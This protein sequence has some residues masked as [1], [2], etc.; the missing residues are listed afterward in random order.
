MD[1]GSDYNTITENNLSGGVIV[2]LSNYEAVDH[3]Y[4]ND[5]STKYPNATEID[6]SGAGNQPYV[7]YTAQ[8]GTQPVYY[9]DNHPLMKPVAI[10]LTGSNPLVTSSP[11]PTVPE[12][13]WLAILPLFISALFIAVI[14]RQRKTHQVKKA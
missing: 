5:Y 9:Q 7:Y 6:H 2:W 14:F 1:Y 8:N 11:S 13:S 3:N 10:P 4:W 12:F